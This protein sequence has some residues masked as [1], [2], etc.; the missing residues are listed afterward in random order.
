M[1]FTYLSQ[2]KKNI[3]IYINILNPFF[4][5]LDTYDLM[6]LI[7]QLIDLISSHNTYQ[8]HLI[9]KFQYIRYIWFK[10]YMYNNYI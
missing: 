8:T 3:Y 1:K 9:I 2:K 7:L 6:D 4:N 5:I 10:S